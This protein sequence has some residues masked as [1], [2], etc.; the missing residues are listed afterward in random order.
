MEKKDTPI[1]LRVPKSMKEKLSDLAWKNRISLN[2]Y[3]IDLLE[4]HL[5]NEYKKH[6]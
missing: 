3:I 1:G 5:H 6:L 2:A 4:N